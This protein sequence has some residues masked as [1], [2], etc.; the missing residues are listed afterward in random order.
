MEFKSSSSAVKCTKTCKDNFLNLL[1]TKLSIKLSPKQ[2]PKKLQLI[3]TDFGLPLQFVF[4]DIFDYVKLFYY[5][6]LLA[7]RFRTFQKIII[8]FNVKLLK[9]QFIHL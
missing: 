3:L 7:C 4:T 8:K 2:S 1:L 5:I 9:K 6:V